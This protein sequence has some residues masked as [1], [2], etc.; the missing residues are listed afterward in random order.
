MIAEKASG[1]SLGELYQE[2]IFDPLGLETAVLIEGVP[3]EGEIT[4]QGY[5]LVDGGPA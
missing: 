5:W 2:R 3:Q 4:M 1:Q